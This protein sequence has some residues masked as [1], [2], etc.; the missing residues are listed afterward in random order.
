MEEENP[1]SHGHIYGKVF[2]DNFCILDPGEIEHH[3]KKKC[4]IWHCYM[5]Y[6]VKLGIV[7]ILRYQIFTL[8]WGPTP[9]SV[10]IMKPTSSSFHTL[11]FFTK[12][13]KKKLIK[14]F[15]KYKKTNFFS[16]DNWKYIH[17]KNSNNFSNIF[18]YRWDDVI[19]GLTPS[20]PRN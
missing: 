2:I 10:V 5:W 6:K 8:L 9:S 4:K 13:L 3:I 12:K 15:E 1:C 17:L 19:I 20:C 7:H 16:M 11:K 18:H 14:F